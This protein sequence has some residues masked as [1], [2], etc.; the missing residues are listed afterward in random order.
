MV[1]SSVSRRFL[2]ALVLTGGNQAGGRHAADSSCSTQVVESQLYS[3][4]SDVWS[5]GCTLIQ[6]AAGNPPYSNYSNHFAAL[7]AIVEGSTPPEIPAHM[8]VEFHDAVRSCFQRDASKRPF[9]QGLLDSP[10]LRSPGCV[11]FSSPCSPGSCA[12]CADV[13]SCT[14]FLLV[15]MPKEM[16]QETAR[17]CYKKLLCQAYSSA[18]TSA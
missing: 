17:K 5:V 6:M 4:K 7:F 1:S 2:V 18:P 9:V 13:V 14:I 10:F 3:R 15:L 16:L 11:L 12:C 8:S